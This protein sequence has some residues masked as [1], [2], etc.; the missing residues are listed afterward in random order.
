MCPDVDPREE[1]RIGGLKLG[2]PPL[3]LGYVYG[4]PGGRCIVFLPSIHERGR[5]GKKKKGGGPSLLR[6][7]FDPIRKER[8]G[9]RGGAKFSPERRQL[10]R[11]GEEGELF[12][13]APSHFRL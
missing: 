12:T 11:G 4:R 5:G 10:E 9:G 3:G 7:G 13:L 2:M 8:E 6:S 1:K